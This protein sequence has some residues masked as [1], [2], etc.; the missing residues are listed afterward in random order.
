[1]CPA[2]VDLFRESVADAHVLRLVAAE[3]PLGDV[4]HALGVGDSE[5]PLLLLGAAGGHGQDG[6]NGKEEQREK[7]VERN[8]YSNVSTWK[9]RKE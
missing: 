2:L 6:E 7:E 9:G 1:M 3:Q 5:A 8:H 4:V